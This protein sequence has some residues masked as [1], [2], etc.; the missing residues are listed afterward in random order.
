MPN[1]KP[2]L[3]THGPHIFSFSFDFDDVPDGTGRETTG[4]QTYIGYP[5]IQRADSSPNIQFSNVLP[6]L[7]LHHDKHKKIYAPYSYLLFSSTVFPARL[8]LQRCFFLL[9]FV[10][11]FS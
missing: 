11:N 9:N 5:L 1:M 7:A 3:T 6:K 8:F 2:S 4:L 10:K